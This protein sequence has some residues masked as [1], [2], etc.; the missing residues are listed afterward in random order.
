MIVRLTN[1][2]FIEVDSLNHTL[3]QK[4]ISKAKDGTEKESEKVIGYYSSMEGAI[5]GF[6]KHNQNDLLPD[7]YVEMSEYIKSIECINNDAVESLK[8]I[9]GV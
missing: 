9:I 6:V 5:K 7:S 1:G 4:Y 8:R 3:K 2:Y